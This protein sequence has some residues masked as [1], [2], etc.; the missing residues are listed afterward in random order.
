MDDDTSTYLGKYGYSIIK[1]YLPQ[2]ELQT[3]RK[4]LNVSPFVPKTSL[5]KP[6]PFRVFKETPTKIYIPRFYGIE[7]YGEPE[8]DL[9]GYGEKINIKFNGSLRD[10]QKPIVDAFLKKAKKDG[11]G[12]LEI[13]A[14]AG[15][16]CMGLFIAAALGVKTLIVVH[17]EFLLRQW[18]E[19]IEQ[20]LPDAKVGRLQRNIIDIEGK[21][22][23]I[24]MLQSLSMKTYDKNIFKSFGFT[25]Y[26]EVHHVS[27]EVFSR[28]LL[29]IVT[30][31]SL[32]LSA[33]MNRKDGLT[34]VIKMF[35]GGVAYKLERQNTHNVVVKA[36]NYVNNNEDFS[37]TELNFRGQTHYSLMIKKICEYNHRTEFILEL[38]KHILKTTT[39]PDMQ[40]IILGHN[41]SLLTYLFDAIS[42]RKISTVGYYIGGM[43]EEQLK[44]SET[45]KVII[46]TYAMAEE[47][48][49][50]K[51]LTTLIM[52]TPKVDVT[53]SVGRIL[54]K[55]HDQAIV[56][57]IVDTHSLFQKHY[58]KRKTFYRKSKFRIEETDME[59]YK[60]NKW[61]VVYDPVNKI[62]KAFKSKEKNEDKLLQGVCL[63][64]D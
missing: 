38:L 62:K 25:I 35:L 59:G 49:D 48:L 15:K 7:T 45:K 23:V 4:E 53:Q 57:D 29:K 8:K 13:Y 9:L 39:N 63:I 33:T 16:T 22:I 64:S 17:K 37:R 27:A 24:G 46:A 19:R 5:N 61:E 58:K 10:Y 20:F 34:K 52:A 40:I 18:I 11:S 14:G 36:I 21:D 26:D 32:G 2:K 43:K 60:N 42:H 31:Y 47:G 28:A 44:E 54:R 41:K 51:T 12:L 1:E 50:I 56:V 55:K 3:I 30:R 6:T